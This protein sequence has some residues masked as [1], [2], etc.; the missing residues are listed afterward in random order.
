MWV[1][2]WF[3]SLP[4]T[5]SHALSVFALHLTQTAQVS[6]P[7]P[8]K[9]D[10]KF[11]IVED[12]HKPKSLSSGCTYKTQAMFIEKSSRIS[13]IYLI[14]FL[15]YFLLRKLIIFWCSSQGHWDIS[16]AVFNFLNNGGHK[17]KHACWEEA[18][19]FHFSSLC[20]VEKWFMKLWKN[21][22]LKILNR[23]NKRLFSKTAFLII[24]LDYLRFKIRLKS[25]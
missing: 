17:N 18:W 8:F 22:E 24:V 6:V 5:M 12:S 13:K 21:I 11:A 20:S 14:Y 3:P 10:F 25:D 4:H 7:S 1:G 9:H 16:H 15:L 2:H 23:M 19:G